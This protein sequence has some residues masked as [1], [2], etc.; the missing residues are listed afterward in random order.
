MGGQYFKNKIALVTGAGSGIGMALCLHLAE[1]GAKVVCTDINLEN[2]TETSQIIG[3][4]GIAYYLN[5]ADEVSVNDLV[6]LVAAKYGRI[7][8][9]F[10]NAGI[11]VSGELRDIKLS[12]WKKLMDINFYGVL[13]GSQAAYQVML[14]QGS[15]HIVNIASAAG[16]A[17]GLA[18][19]APYSVSKH[20][21]VNYT[22]ILRVEGKALGIRA[23]V[24]C[25]GF[26]DTAI[27]KSAIEA[28]AKPNWKN[29]ALD[30]LK[31][32]VSPEKAAAL[33]LKGVASNKETIVFPG[34][35]KIAMKADRI[36]G[37]VVK[38]MMQKELSDFRKN[39]RLPD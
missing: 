7:D 8:F 4:Q 3:D 36:F 2:A 22:H 20:A 15:G 29:K 23:S 21:V 12:D 9:I 14:K 30:A 11:A 6:D 1:A 31:K 28:N 32:G 16:L 18:L 33:I 35:I 13:Y 34:A 39:Y 5:V 17:D 27:G 26:V 10:N 25:P 38:I 19:M 24:V 37:G